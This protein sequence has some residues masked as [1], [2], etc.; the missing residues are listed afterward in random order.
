MWGPGVPGLK[1]FAKLFVGK[2]EETLNV[3]N[4]CSQSNDIGVKVQNLGRLF[5]QSRKGTTRITRLYAVGY[6]Q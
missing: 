3:G 1:G 4:N 5:N 6:L 2:S